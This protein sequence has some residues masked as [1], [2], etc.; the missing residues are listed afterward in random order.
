M[1]ARRI[2]FTLV[3]LLVVIAIIG[4]LIALL[5]PAVQAAREA[6]RR[7]QCINNLKQVSLAMHNYHD[8]YKT[9]PRW[10]YQACTTRGPG[11][12]GDYTSGNN[13]WWTGFTAMTM[14]LPYVEQGAIYDKIAWGVTPE[15]NPNNQL[16][17]LA[18][19]SAYQC[20]SD[21][22][23]ADTN[24]PAYC[25][26]KVSAGAGW[27]NIGTTRENGV[28]RRDA[29]TAIRDV[30]D[31][32]SSTIFIGEILLGDGIGSKFSMGD[33]VYRVGG[34]PP[35]Y[36]FPTQAEM[37]TWGPICEAGMTGTTMSS[38]GRRYWQPR[39]DDGS[40]FTPIVPP[41]WRYPN[42]SDSQWSTGYTFIAARSRHPGGAN[43]SLTDASVRFISETIDFDT[44]QSL[45]S[46]N[47][48][49][50]VGDF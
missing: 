1:A 4:I 36:V 49:N 9:F 15:D 7:S 30:R 50:P 34:R 32:T 3:E 38:A 21:S 35:V 20:P 43:H 5:L 11:G 18:P 37:A 17:R 13:S 46:R 27:L 40:P 14:I 24:Y 29:E 41:N 45:G 2:G 31:G 44:Y 23:Y 39:V 42:C 19:I 47:E 26:Y 33:I 12:C 22:K 6:A 10:T 28:F 16:F 25:N 48:G 8:V